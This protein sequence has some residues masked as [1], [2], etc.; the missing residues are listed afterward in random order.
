[1]G[2]DSVDEYEDW[3]IDA[4]DSEAFECACVLLAILEAQP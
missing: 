1:M 2:F 3:L 4:S